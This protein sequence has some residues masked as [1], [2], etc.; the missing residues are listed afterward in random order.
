MIRTQVLP[1]TLRYQA[2]LADVVG[3]TNAAGV[4]CSDTE[5]N[6]RFVVDLASQMYGGL[7]NIQTILNS[8]PSDATKHALQAHEKLLPAMDSIREACDT[9]ESMIPSEIWPLPTYAQMLLLDR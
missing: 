6:L 7:E 2:E 8:L 5:K 4:D 3:S 9:A 1:A